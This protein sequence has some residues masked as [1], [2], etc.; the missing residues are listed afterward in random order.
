ML[1]ALRPALPTY[2]WAAGGLALL[3]GCDAGL[4]ARV[5]RASG[6]DAMVSTPALAGSGA[7]AVHP[8]TTQSRALNTATAL[9]ARPLRAASDRSHWVKLDPERM[10]VATSRWTPILSEPSPG[11]Q[12]IGY[13]RSGQRVARQPEPV[14]FEG[15]SGGF[16]GIEPYGYVCVGA[17]ASIDSEHV[18]VRATVEPDREALLPYRYGLSAYPTPP[19]YTRIPTLA[20]QRR[21]ESDLDEHLAESSSVAWAPWPFE[22]IP[23]FLRDGQSSLHVNGRRKNANVLFTQRAVVKSAYA[24][25]T[26]FEANGRGFGITTDY[27]ILPLDRLRPVRA[28]EFQGV[29][30]NEGWQLPIAFVRAEDA[31]L[32]AEDLEREELV[33]VRRIGYREPFALSGKRTERDGQRYLQTTAGH[34]LKETS[35]VTRIDRFSRPPRWATPGRTWI[36]ISLLKQSLVAYEGEHP[37]YATLVS[38][39]A[40]GVAEPDESKAT[41]QGQF[42]IHTKYLSAGMS[43]NAKDA[44]FDLREV[45]YVQYFSGDYALHAAYWH[46]SFGIPLSQGCI[47]LSPKDARWLFDWT[48]PT[49][50][51]NWS[52]VLSAAEG[53]LVYIHP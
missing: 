13:L 18:L 31:E 38:T 21:V 3:S 50:P 7:A 15:C 26:L 23:E 53:T 2:G 1:T 48:E 16:F 9:P 19:F 24:L 52:G 28:S 12:Q 29:A 40:D 34:W 41:I 42:L 36:D 46:D 49:L 30:L 14:A 44:V 20:E 10:L 8:P 5:E 32:Y 25:M 6:V 17:R 27:D 11:A 33:V 37:V 43:S 39:G 4:P 22:A 35:R 51:P 47:N 45:P